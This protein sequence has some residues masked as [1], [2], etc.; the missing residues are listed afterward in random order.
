MPRSR[1]RNDDVA[2]IISLAVAIGVLVGGLLILWIA[3]AKYGSTGTAERCWLSG[4]EAIYGRERPSWLGCNRFTIERHSGRWIVRLG[5][6]SISA[7]RH[8][9]LD[10]AS[11]APV[12][13]P[14]GLLTQS[15]N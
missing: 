4:L 11:Q 9:G 15:A 3:P 14:T 2:V 7:L 8:S 6:V 1:S 13:T 10:V 5:T 12:S